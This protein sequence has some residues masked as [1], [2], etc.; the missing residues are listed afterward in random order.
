[1]SENRIEPTTVANAAE[2]ARLASITPASPTGTPLVP[3]KFVPYLMALV[4][5]AGIPAAL[6]GVG[7]I[8]P[9]VVN[10]IAAAVGIVA[11]VLLGGSPGLRKHP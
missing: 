11:V 6:L 8:L 7:I 1:M 2:D 4:G 10:G 3:A 5:L 9:P